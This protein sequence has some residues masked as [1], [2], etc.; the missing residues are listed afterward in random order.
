MA[1]EI[2]KLL[3]KFFDA[4]NRRDWGAYAKYLS[5]DIEWTILGPPVR[6]VIRGKKEYVDTMKGF[7]STNK[8]KFYIVSIAANRDRAIVMAELEMDSQRSVD[9]FEFRD[10]LIF[11]EREYYDDHYWL[12]E[13]RNESAEG[14]MTGIRNAD[15]PR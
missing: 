4:E 9:I 15:E 2:D 6:R 1:V 8:S 14:K 5:D 11:R 12:A 3:L 10:G 7:Y 13:S